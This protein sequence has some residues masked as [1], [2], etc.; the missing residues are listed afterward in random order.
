MVEILTSKDFD[1]YKKSIENRLNSNEKKLEDFVKDVDEKYKRAQA[2]L[3][4]ALKGVNTRIDDLE[5]SSKSFVVRLKGAIT[6]SPSLL[7][8][9]PPPTRRARVCVPRN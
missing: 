5:E 9:K 2:D 7:R 4:K 3:D 1:E 6:Q 8:N